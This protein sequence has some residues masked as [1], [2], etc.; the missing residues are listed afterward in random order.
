MIAAQARAMPADLL[1]KLLRWPLAAFCV[2]LLILGA[3]SYI[4]R[5]QARAEAAELRATTAETRATLNTAVAQIGATRE[6]EIATIAPAPTV[7][8]RLRGLCQQ[9]VRPADPAAVDVLGPDPDTL[10]GPADFDGLAA[11]LAACQANVATLKAR[12]AVLGEIYAANP[13]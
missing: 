9:P 4:G 10:S 5:L 3:K 6:I 8:T 7:S 13:Q 1:W 11:D 2:L 12:G